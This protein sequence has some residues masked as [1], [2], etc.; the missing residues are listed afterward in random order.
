M[1]LVEKRR[2]IHEIRGNKVKI[3]LDNHM[4][5]EIQPWDLGKAV[6]ARQYFLVSRL[7]EG[8]I[9][10]SAIFYPELWTDPRKQSR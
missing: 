7:V 3:A 6:I 4:H 9:E 8:P 5:V 10:K 1:L 2:I